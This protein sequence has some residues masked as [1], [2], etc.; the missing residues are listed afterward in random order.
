MTVY[1][2]YEFYLCLKISLWRE[3][4]SSVLPGKKAFEA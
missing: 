3:I 4:I 2:N 1:V